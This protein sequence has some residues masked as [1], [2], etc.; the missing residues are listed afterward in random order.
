[1]NQ[2]NLLQDESQELKHL[3]MEK[4]DNLINHSSHDA[5]TTPR[6]PKGFRV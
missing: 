1:M 5:V 4:D 3:N 6:W 2:I